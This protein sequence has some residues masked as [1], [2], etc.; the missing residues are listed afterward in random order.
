LPGA[1]DP[2]RCAR[3]QANK[4]TVILLITER[5]VEGAG[6]ALPH[7]PVL[8]RQLG[9]ALI[10]RCVRVVDGLGGV[11]LGDLVRDHG[12]YAVRGEILI[13][14]SGAGGMFAQPQGGQMRSYG[15]QLAVDLIS[16]DSETRI[17]SVQEGSQLLGINPGNAIKAGRDKTARL[18]DPAA[19][20]LV[21]KL[22]ERLRGP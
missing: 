19:D 20:Q 17:V 14:Q 8:A 4:A 16:L 22:D 5:A 7:T 11:P 2:D 21:L 13:S 9:D 3:L 1:P 10:K 15:I 18:V 6:Q 12:P